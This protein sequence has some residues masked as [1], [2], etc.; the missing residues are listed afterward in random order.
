M[1]YITFKILTGVIILLCTDCLVYEG[2]ANVEI[3]ISMGSKMSI[4][5][6]INYMNKI[7]E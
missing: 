3:E 4:Q 7:S 5:K 2:D 1:I 6:S